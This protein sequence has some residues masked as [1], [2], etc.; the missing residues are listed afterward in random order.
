RDNLAAIEAAPGIKRGTDGGPAVSP[1]V[2]LSVNLPRKGDGNVSALLV[3]GLTPEFG[4]V[5]PEI[6]IT[7]GRM[8]ATGLHEIVIGKSAHD[9]FAH[10]D[11]GDTASFHNGEWKV[12]GRFT[13]D[14]D[15][16]E[17]EAL[18]D[19]TTLMSAAQRTL[20]SAVTV[21]LD[22][23][24]S[25][26][27]FKEALKHDPTLKVDVQRET[28]YYEGQSKQVAALLEIVATTVGGIMAVGA[29]FGALN[30]MYSAVSTRTVEIA[31]LR[32]IGFGALPVVV[33]VM[34]EAQVLAFIGAVAGGAIAWMLFNG[35]AFSTGGA[36]GQVAVRLHV[37]LPL[38]AA[39]MTW[40]AVVGL[41]G[42]L[43]PAI[44]AARSS[45][46]DSLRVV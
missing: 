24:D 22:S 45:V 16:H 19:A 30:T 41:F 14:G 20:F 9:Q 42:G 27:P 36:L 46:V 3:R 28:E 13:S 34:V 26:E 6:Q 17:S 38:V 39:G 7:E 18:G 12:V 40:A 5:R 35:N 11:V 43:F 4:G 10:L 25:F 1:E 15:V 44:R 33:S 29:L 32:A 37:G 8:F 31:T 21:T 23:K 2:L